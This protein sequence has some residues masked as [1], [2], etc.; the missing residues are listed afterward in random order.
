M[1]VPV[2]LLYILAAPT[3]L[4]LAAYFLPLLY[5]RLRG[6]QDLKKKYGA[7]WAV[8]TGGS[9]GIG[10]AICEELAKQGL[11]VVVAALPDKFLEP[12]V[13]ELSAA[14]KGQEFVAVGVSF[15]PGADY[16]EK[17]KAATADKDVQIV[18]NNAGFIVTGFFDT[19]PLGKHLVNMECNATAAVAIT[20]HFAAAMMRKGLKGCIV[21]TSS[22]SA[23]IPN[24]FAIIYGATKAFMSQ[25][26]ASIAVELQCK[27]IDVCVIHPSPVAS[28]FYNKVEHKIDS[29]ES[30]KKLAVDPSE[31]PR[32]IFA[33]IGRCVLRDVGNT[34]VGMR[35]GVALLPYSALAHIIALVAPFLPDYVEN[36]K[37]RGQV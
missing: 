2:F 10:R 12:A 26:A 1:A 34:A 36:D 31:L 5:I 9:T 17:I 25:F 28:N 32:E 21:F 8:V 20:H 37:K 4:W 3:A 6:V 19:Q 7:T 24:P 11:N 16:L 23:Y 33:S 22:A 14:Y 13:A 15:A 29:M 18:F 30:F 27:G 35:L